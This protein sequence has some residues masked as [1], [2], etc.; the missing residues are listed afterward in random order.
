M[1]RCEAETTVTIDMKKF[2]KKYRTGEN[3]P[4]VKGVLGGI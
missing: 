4:I 2:P 1:K 3:N